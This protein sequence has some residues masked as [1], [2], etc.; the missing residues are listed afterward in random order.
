[1]E[2]LLLSPIRKGSVAWDDPSTSLEKRQ[3]SGIY[4][5][6]ELPPYVLQAFRR[7]TVNVDLVSVVQIGDFVT[8][9][10][11]SQVRGARG[12]PTR[13]RLIAYRQ[14]DVPAYTDSTL[15]LLLPVLASPIVQKIVDASVLTIDSILITDPAPTSLGTHLVGAITQ[16]GPFDAV[17]SFPQGLTVYWNGA[18]LGQIAM[19]DVHAAADVGA[20]LDLDATLTVADVGHLTDFTRYLLTE[21]SF[22]WDIQGG[23]V[24]VA[25]LGIVT[26][27]I[28]LSKSVTLSGMNGLKNAVT[29]TH[30]DLPSNDP[31]G[32]I[33]LLV[34][35]T[36]VNPASVGLQTSEMSFQTFFGQTNIGPV[37]AA[38]PFVLAPKSNVN[39]PLVGRLVPQDGE[40]GL[41]DVSTIFNGCKLTTS[42]KSDVITDSAAAVIHGIPSTIVVNGD[43][44]GPPGVSWLNDGIKAL[45]TPTVFPAAANLQIINSITMNAM[46]LMFTESSAWSPDFSTP[47]A[48]AAFQLPFAFPLDITRTYAIP[49]ALHKCSPPDVEM[50]VQLT[51]VDQGTGFA[52]LNIP[53]SPTSTD[54]V[55]RIATLQIS[56]VPF[57][58]ASNA[59]AVFSQFLTDT[60]DDA[61]K[62]FG[63][64]GTANSTRPR[65]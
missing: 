31:A 37:A 43:T 33:H 13:W 27:G 60:T 50:A 3:G 39:L 5:G 12:R 57:A 65:L 19:P 22:T 2:D 34:D 42:C 54:V 24:A 63:L 49:Q 35:S 14:R 4:P 40:Q 56:H 6:F 62:T 11:Y 48:L 64:V 25:A 23:G 59:H 15:L 47:S 61:S 30:F 26:T 55:S 16:A 45:K 46:T 32:G 53:M 51:T 20:A 41:A 44:A 7:L 38:G 17:I 21:P 58:V 28:S 10:T 52:E 18:A 8:D 1:M 36:I 9:L 29:I